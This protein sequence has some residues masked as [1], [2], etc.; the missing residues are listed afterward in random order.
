MVCHWIPPLAL[1]NPSCSTTSSAYSI[2]VFHSS[3]RRSG[4][5]SLL[6]PAN[7]QAKMSLDLHDHV[8]SITE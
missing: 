7:V 3:A 4:L 5:S 1:Y 2:P 6:S 8:V